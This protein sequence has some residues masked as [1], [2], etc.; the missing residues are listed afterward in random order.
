MHPSTHLNNFYPEI[1]GPIFFKFHVEPSVN[2]GGG[3]G[4]GG[5]EGGG[6]VENLFRWLLFVNQDDNHA[7]IW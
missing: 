2:G 4:G 6:G 7:H 1:P 3:G 5:G